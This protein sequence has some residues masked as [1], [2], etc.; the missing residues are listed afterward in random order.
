MLPGDNENEPREIMR[1]ASLMKDVDVIIP[2][3]FNR[4]SRSLFRQMLSYIYRGII[5]TTFFTTFNYTN[6]TVMYRTSVL[7][8]LGFRNSG[9]FYQTDI[10]V[11]LVTGGYLFAEVPYRLR[12]RKKGRS[13]A[14]S[15]RS[16]RGVIKGYLKLVFDIYLSKKAKQA[17][18]DPASVTARRCSY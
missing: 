2:F 5:N 17:A 6:G 8:A 16:L 1:Y 3:V 9:F 10:L 13:K 12:G 18:F 15:L 4:S 11:R 7:K 14:V